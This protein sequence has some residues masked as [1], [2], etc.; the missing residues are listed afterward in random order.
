[1]DNLVDSLTRFSKLSYLKNAKESILDGHQ[2]LKIFEV[3]DLGT[4]CNSIMD[5]CMPILHSSAVIQIENCE[6]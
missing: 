4:K 1:M 2:K 5:N 3:R 6:M